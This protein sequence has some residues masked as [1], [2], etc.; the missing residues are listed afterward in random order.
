M[1]TLAQRI[2]IRNV[3]RWTE[4]WGKELG[5]AS[6]G[7]ALPR[8]MPVSCLD[9][10]ASAAPRL[11]FVYMATDFLLHSASYASLNATRIATIVFKHSYV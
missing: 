8:V 3:P 5:H 9:K 2:K 6:F 10:S 1:M 11:S 7:G 4:H